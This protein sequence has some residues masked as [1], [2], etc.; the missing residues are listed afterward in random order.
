[1][2]AS[3]LSW[4]PKRRRARGPG[5]RRSRS[6]GRV[7]SRAVPPL[8]PFRAE[9]RVPPLGEALRVLALAFI[10][11]THPRPV[12]LHGP[13]FLAALDA[14]AE[15]RPHT[16]DPRW[17]RFYLSP[18]F[19]AFWTY[20][21]AAAALASKDP[22]RRAAL[23]LPMPLPDL[24]DALEARLEDVLAAEVARFERNAE[25]T[26][27]GPHLRT[28][29]AYA[30]V[31]VCS[32][33][34]YHLMARTTRTANIR[35]FIRV[36]ARVYRATRLPG[37]NFGSGQADSGPPNAEDFI[38]DCF[39]SSAFF[40][41]A[42]HDAWS[43]ADAF[44]AAATQIIDPALEF[45]DAEIL[46]HG[47]I[48]DRLPAAALRDPSAPASPEL[49]RARY[50]VSWRDYVGWFD[51]RYCD[52]ADPGSRLRALALVRNMKDYGALVT[53]GM[54]LFVRLAIEDL[55]T[56]LRSIGLFRLDLLVAED[57]I[58]KGHAVP[59]RP[60]HPRPP[61]PPRVAR[62][63]DV[64]LS[65]PGLP[66]ALR[67][68]AIVRWALDAIS[69]ALPSDLLSA[70]RAGSWDDF[71]A[72]LPPHYSPGE[73]FQM[74]GYLPFLLESR[75]VVRCPEPFVDLSSDPGALHP[76]DIRSPAGDASI[77]PAMLRLWSRTRAFS[78]VPAEAGAAA[79][80]VRMILD[81]G[82]LAI[83]LVVAIACHAAAV[84][85]WALILT[86][87]ALGPAADPGAAG[88][89]A[90]CMSM[91]AAGGK[92]HRAVALLLGR[93]LE[94]G[95]VEMGVGE[96]EMLR[97]GRQTRPACGHA[98]VG[99]VEGVCWGCAMERMEAS[100]DAEEGDERWSESER[101]SVLSEASVGTGASTAS[102]VPESAAA[103]EPADPA[104]ARP[105]WTVLHDAP[106]ELAR[107]MPAL[108]RRVT[109]SSV[110]EVYETFSSDEFPEGR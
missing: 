95:S 11:A 110:R 101:A 89:V 31:Y 105:V 96:L 61:V 62:H 54:V 6:L 4:A 1:M 8:F 39:W 82:G 79:R 107:R 15:G 64:V 22:A 32:F 78:E 29:E 84:A 26:G 49:L 30:I 5:M 70:I 69:I 94:T 80:M 10:A 34:P 38:W 40:G 19:E 20:A 3:E 77:R 91:L 97:S 37:E 28:P 68:S 33:A 12:G 23:K 48:F 83:G 24:V 106:E 16:G 41:L 57:L 27:P 59:G 81:S 72:S 51:H 100:R 47:G 85:S 17:P 63:L 88:M 46:P 60:L 73:R 102:L 50:G 35:G 65:N 76:P 66:E 2:P 56:F 53:C 109:F 25:K 90:A 44:G 99:E 71:A 86:A 87:R 98:G 67:R 55:S 104:F 36:G 75:T 93:V 92:Q 108:R 7:A 21:T 43:A 74:L 103:A 9:R 13:S 18:V 52:A 58:A 45:P 42:F 14:R